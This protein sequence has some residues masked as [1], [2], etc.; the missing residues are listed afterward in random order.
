MIE[1]SNCRHGKNKKNIGPKSI[2]RDNKTCEERKSK[3][4]M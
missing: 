3:G 4:T 2:R 1:K